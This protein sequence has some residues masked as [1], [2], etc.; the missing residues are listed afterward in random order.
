MELDLASLKSIN[1]F[2]D[3]VKA[4]NKPV[5]IL[6]NN[7]GVMACPYNTTTDGFELQ[8]GTN[9]FGPFHLTRSLLPLLSQSGTK[10]SPARVIN[11]SSCANILWSPPKGI[12]FDDIAG[13]KH[14]HP[15]T[16]YGES[17]LAAILFTRELNKRAPPNVISVALHPG[18]I[19][20]T[21]LGRFINFSSLMGAI[22]M[23][24]KNGHLGL[25]AK[26]PRKTIAHGSSTTVLAALDPNIKP[27]EYYANCN[28]CKDI[29][30]AAS[31]PELQV[32]LWEVSE[33]MVDEALAKL[34]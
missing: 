32:K 23:V 29:H 22:W 19:Q 26:E 9:H 24:A 4:L 8:I 7:A 15:F 18:V 1:A 11:L 20:S 16:R 25:A 27:D 12:D 6:I 5:H 21:N 28:P 31:N 13:T 30:P 17:K 14:Y 34:Q 2:V 3:K 33:K 10:E